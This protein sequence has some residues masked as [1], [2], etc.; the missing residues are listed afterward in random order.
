MEL[1]IRDVRQALRMLVGNRGFAA[2]ALLTI[3]LG[4]GGTTAVFSVVYGG[5]LRPLPY[6]EPQSLVRLWEEHPGANAP[7]SG[8]RLSQPT[9]HAWRRSSTTLEGVDAFGVGEVA[10]A[11]GQA[12]VAERV[13]IARITPSVFRLLRV[14]PSIGR[15][16][17]DSESRSG[18]APVVVLGYAMWRDRF[19]GQPSIIG[20]SIAIDGIEHQVIGVAPPGFAFPTRESGVP[21]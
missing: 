18:A 3:A 19:G 21:D 7:F 12:I 17:S 20:R 6:A 15:F 2:A 9:Y 16:F 5:L 1:L 10:V 14:S 11:E 8:V 13:R 4:V